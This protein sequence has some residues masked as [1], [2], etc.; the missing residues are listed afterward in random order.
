MTGARSLTAGASMGAG[1]RGVVL[2]AGSV[3]CVGST[4]VAILTPGRA[5]A[6]EGG[7]GERV[8]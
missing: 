6:T 5:W 1:R 2:R 3:S 7:E 8:S 4:S